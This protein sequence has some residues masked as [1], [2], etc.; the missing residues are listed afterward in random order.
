VTVADVA[1]AA[2]NLKEKSE[3]RLRKNRGRKNA[4]EQFFYSTTLKASML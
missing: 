2:L 4:I 3:K 1:A